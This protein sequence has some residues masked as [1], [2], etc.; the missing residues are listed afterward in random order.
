VLEI[1]SRVTV[2]GGMAKLSLRDARRTANKGAGEDFGM[3]G[4]WG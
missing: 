4:D 3:R 2:A 1:L